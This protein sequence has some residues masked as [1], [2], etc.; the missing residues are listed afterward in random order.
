MSDS[1]PTPYPRRRPRLGAPEGRLRAF[2]VILW[3]WAGRA[4]CRALCADYPCPAGVGG[5]AVMS[6]K[7]LVRKAAFKAMGCV[8]IAHGGTV[9]M[10]PEEEWAAVLRRGNRPVWF[11]RHDPRHSHLYVMYRDGD[12]DATPEE[13]AFY[14]GLDLE[15]MGR[16]G[17]TFAEPGDPDGFLVKWKGREWDRERL[18]SL[19]AVREVEHA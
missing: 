14:L 16:T 17:L 12:R 18:K 3:R 5:G 4:A 19:P 11:P 15:H 6:V 2:P 8:E 10:S 1:I 7:T 13:A 9:G